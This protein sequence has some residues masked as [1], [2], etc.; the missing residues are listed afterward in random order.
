MRRMRTVLRLDRGVL[1]PA[2]LVCIEMKE[3]I[4]LLS[5]SKHELHMIDTSDRVLTHRANTVE[6]PVHKRIDDLGIETKLGP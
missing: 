5:I 6:G 1:D 3:L 2:G 4:H